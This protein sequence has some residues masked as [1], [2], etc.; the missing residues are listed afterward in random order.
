[1]QYRMITQQ[2]TSLN[3]ELQHQ[4]ERYTYKK[5]FH[6]S[7]SIISESFLSSDI[8]SKH[9]PSVLCRGKTIFINSRFE[10]SRIST[11]KF[12]KV[13]LSY[14]SV[15]FLAIDLFAAN[16]PFRTNNIFYFIISSQSFRGNSP[17]QNGAKVLYA[18][19]L[20][21]THRLKNHNFSTGKSDLV[22]PPLQ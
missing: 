13:D 5:G 22:L 12:L 10:R 2:K 4:G 15:L 16:D 11:E 19:S 6:I 1:M 17:E 9:P 18:R 14:S 8:E 7:L 20:C 3:Q 21:L